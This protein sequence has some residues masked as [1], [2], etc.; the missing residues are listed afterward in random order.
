MCWTK[1]AVSFLEPELM[2]PLIIGVFERL[3]HRAGLSGTVNTA[4]ESLHQLTHSHPRWL[5]LTGSAWVA[6]LLSI[7]GDVTLVAAA[8]KKVEL[9]PVWRR[10]IWEPVPGR[11][12][13]RFKTGSLLWA[14]MRAILEVKLDIW[15]VVRNGGE[16]FHDQGEHS[17]QQARSYRGIMKDRA[18]E[19]C[20]RALNQMLPFNQSMR[21]ESDI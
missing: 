3:R 2:A 15:E 8:K 10:H 19:S 9:A 11:I 6:A 5:H 16:R 12:L 20:C 14:V 4:S 7:G 18:D 1:V 21:S 17:R 13:I